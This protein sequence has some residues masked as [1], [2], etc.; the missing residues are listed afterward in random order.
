[1]AYMIIAYIVIVYVVIA[2]EPTAVG[3]ELLPGMSSLP[4][5]PMLVHMCIGMCMDK[6]EDMCTE[7]C[8][9]V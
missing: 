9:R 4:G 8:T 6:Y 1:M 7:M 3:D 2:A 5:S